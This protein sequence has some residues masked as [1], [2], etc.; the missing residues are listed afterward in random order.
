MWGY[1]FILY[2]KFGQALYWPFI[3][4]VCEACIGA[5]WEGD[6]AVL[7]MHLGSAMA[8]SLC[9]SICL[10]PGMQQHLAYRSTSKIPLNIPTT[11]SIINNYLLHRHCIIFTIGTSSNN[12]HETAMQGSVPLPCEA[13]SRQFLY[14]QSTE[15]S[16]Y[17]VGLEP[18]QPRLGGCQVQSCR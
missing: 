2:W 13:Q 12:M 5:V 8:C 9:D 6:G 7:Q 17:I 14:I 10:N 3:Y 1:G 15:T 4:S 16:S 11:P 18:K